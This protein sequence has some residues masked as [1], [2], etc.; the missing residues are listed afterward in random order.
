[1]TLTL[2]GVSFAGSY[3]PFLI[4]T[5]APCGIPSG[6]QLSVNFRA[7]LLDNFLASSVTPQKTSLCPHLWKRSESALR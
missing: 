5:A 6:L 2:K 3:V 7:I 1:M 4:V